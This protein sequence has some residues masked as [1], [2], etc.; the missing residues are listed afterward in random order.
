MGKN[1]WIVEEYD[2]YL[3]SLMGPGY[4]EWQFKNGLGSGGEPSG[5]QKLEPYVLEMAC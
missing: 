2:T 1:L 3:L 5:A 4:G